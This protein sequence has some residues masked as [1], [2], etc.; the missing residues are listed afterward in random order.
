MVLTGTYQLSIK[1]AKTKETLPGSPFTVAMEAAA[2]VASHSSARFGAGVDKAGV[3]VAGQALTIC[4]SLNDNFGNSTGGKTTSS[5]HA[6]VHKNASA[7]R[8]N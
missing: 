6:S 5:L 3:A 1:D 7:F 2:S 8:W 4:A